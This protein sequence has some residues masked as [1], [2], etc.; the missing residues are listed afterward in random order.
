MGDPEH[1]WLGLRTDFD[2][3][4]GANIFVSDEDNSKEVRFVLNQWQASDLDS[5]NSRTYDF[6]KLLVQNT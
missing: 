1:K 3:P 5:K 4:I 6:L 2:Q